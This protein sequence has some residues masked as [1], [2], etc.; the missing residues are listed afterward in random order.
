MCDPI[1]GCVFIDISPRCDDNNFCTDDKCDKT[2]GQCLNIWKNC[3]QFSDICNTVTCDPNVRSRN[4]TELCSI[5]TPVVCVKYDLKDDCTEALCFLN[6]T[7]LST[8]DPNYHPG[9]C[10]VVNHCSAFYGKGSNAAIIAGALAALAALLILALLLCLA[11]RR[12][13]A[14]S[15]FSGFSSNSDTGVSGN[16]LYEEK[17]RGSSNPLFMEGGHEPYERL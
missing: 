12:G 7:N 17:Y 16:P 11:L 6:T 15:T 1:K 8:T 13:G 9:G 2:T 4:I 3:S 10:E 5:V 14:S